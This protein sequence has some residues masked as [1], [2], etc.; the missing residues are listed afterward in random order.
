LTVFAITTSAPMTLEQL[1]DPLILRSANQL[2]A[3]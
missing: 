1:T 2:V 3:D